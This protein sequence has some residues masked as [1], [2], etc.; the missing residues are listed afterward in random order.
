MRTPI[1]AFQFKRALG[2]CD[3][4]ALAPSVEWRGI[5]QQ[6]THCQSSAKFFCDGPQRVLSTGSD[7]PNS[8]PTAE[9]C[10]FPFTSKNRYNR[11]SVNAQSSFLLPNFAATGGYQYE[12]EN[13][14][15]QSLD[16]TTNL[17][18]DRT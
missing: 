3:R 1:T 4:Q 6:R 9:F 13:A 5:L 17:F 14:T 7:R 16:T 8:V 18:W 2:F 10:D 11:A 15:L 12:V